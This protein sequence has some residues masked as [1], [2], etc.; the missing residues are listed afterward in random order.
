M[1]AHQIGS[2][3]CLIAILADIAVILHSLRKTS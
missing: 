1:T 3:I 2:L